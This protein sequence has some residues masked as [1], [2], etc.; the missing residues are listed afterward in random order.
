PPP[1]P[2]PPP[3]LPR[4]ARDA[5]RGVVAAA[6]RLDE[7]LMRD[8][9]GTLV[10]EHGVVA[11]W[12]HVFT[13]TLA[14]LGRRAAA[15]GAGV[16]VE[17]VTSAAVLHALR[18]V[19]LPAEGG[20]TAALLACAPDEQHTLPLEALGAALSERDSTWRNLGAR[21]P[22]RALLAAVDKIRPAAVVVWAHR[23]DLARGVPLDELVNGSDAVV[24]VAGAGWAEVATPPAVERL[25]SLRDGVRV[26]LRAAGRGD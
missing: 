3:P 2:A 17:H 25:T 20:R 23:D 12:Q 1:P 5:R 4:A 24:A 10:A 8:L 11:A 16:E 19:P 14:E 7:P 13:P 26:V 9:A 21:L 18:G 22:A 6:G 15:R